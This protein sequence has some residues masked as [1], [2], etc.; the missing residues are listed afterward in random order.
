MQ[1]QRPSSQ[2]EGREALL[3][4]LLRWKRAHLTRTEVGLPRRRGSRGG[5]TQDD[6]SELTGYSVKLISM[7]EQGRLHNPTA[8]FLDA[9]AAGLRL[10][11]DERRTLWL[12]AAG[13]APISTSYTIGPD[14]GLTRLVDQIYPHPAYVTDAAWNVHGYNRGVA[15]WFCDFSLVPAHDRNI[16]KWI[17]CYP[18]SQHVFVNWKRDFATVFLARLRAVLSRFPDDPRLISLLAE[19]C[20]RSPLANELW[21]ADADIYVDPPTESRVFRRPGHTDPDQADDSRHHVRLDM[22]ILGALRPDDE[23]RLVVFLLPEGEPHR[24]H[25]R[26]DQSCAACGRESMA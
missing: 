18:H 9:V 11:P 24:P 21:H 16:A 15:E 20:E 1:R 10:T 22:V 8:T 13:T 5:L 14:A 4:A 12:L 6:L 7:L 3:Q 25:V 2:P 23:R 17:F 19:L 26:S